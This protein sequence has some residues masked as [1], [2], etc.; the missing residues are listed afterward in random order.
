V[1]PGSKREFIVDFRQFRRKPRPEIDDLDGALGEP[2]LDNDALVDGFMLW[3]YAL[4]P[5]S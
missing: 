4:F 2:S 3:L 1:R 5:W